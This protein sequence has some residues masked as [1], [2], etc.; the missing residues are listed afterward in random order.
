MQEV[1][2]LACAGERSDGVYPKRCEITPTI[3]R[4]DGSSVLQARHV[5]LEFIRN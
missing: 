5:L 2:G 4:L 1:Y 3:K